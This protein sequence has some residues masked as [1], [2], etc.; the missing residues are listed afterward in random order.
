MKKLIRILFLLFLIQFVATKCNDSCTASLIAG[1]IC[2][3]DDNN[4]CKEI[5]APTIP[6]TLVKET[7]PLTEVATTTP[8]EIETTSFTKNETT[9]IDTTEN[10]VITTSKTETNQTT[11]ITQ[12]TISIIKQESNDETSVVFLGCSK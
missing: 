4:V 10:I 8:K 5:P 12:T 9:S 7:Q 6:T 2:I 3:I 1:F 11:Q